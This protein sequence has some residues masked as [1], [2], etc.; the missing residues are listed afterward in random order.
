MAQENYSTFDF[1]PYESNFATGRREELA[2]RTR[3]EFN[4]N[5]AEYDTLKRTIGALETTDVDSK[6]INTLENDIENTMQGVLETG[7]YDLAN[8]AVSDSLTR[9]MTDNNVKNA[10]ESF[11]TMKKEKQL[12]AANPSK[13]KDYNIVPD[14]IDPETG[15]PTD[16]P[17]RGIAQYDSEGN[18]IMKDLRNSWDS[19]VQGAYLGNSEQVLDHQA[20]AYEIMKN[21]AKDPRAIQLLEKV[22]PGLPKDKA[23]KFLMSGQWLSDE[24]VFGLAE[25]L[26]GLYEGTDEGLQRQKDLSRT[27]NRATSQLFTPEQIRTALIEDLRLAGQTQIGMTQ[28][29]TSI[30]RDPVVKTTDPSTDKTLVYTPYSPGVDL[31]ETK[32]RWDKA[33][34]NIS[35]GKSKAFN[36]DGSLRSNT[37]MPN[38]VYEELSYKDKQLLGNTISA[39]LD[40]DRA[41]ALARAMEQL[42]QV[43]VLDPVTGQPS[44]STN[45]LDIDDDYGRY[46]YMLEKYQDI[47][48]PNA[49]DAEHIEALEKMFTQ[50]THQVRK[51][52]GIPTAGR[53]AIASL[54]TEDIISADTKL[55]DPEV[56][57]GAPVNIDQWSDTLADYFFFKTESDAVENK[58]DLI[59]AIENAAEGAKDFT[60]T[61][62]KIQIRGTSFDPKHPGAYEMIVTRN[63]K[64]GSRSIFVESAINNRQFF[65]PASRL[66]AI[67]QGNYRGVEVPIPTVSADGN[68]RYLKEDILPQR[69]KNGKLSYVSDISLI[70]RAPDGTLISS[71]PGAGNYINAITEGAMKTFLNSRIPGSQVW[72]DQI[73][74]K[75]AY[76]NP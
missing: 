38:P 13:Y 26:V 48:D 35:Q 74:S 19:G 61:P 33:R 16:D 11:Q 4:Q 45:P 42:A 3:Q 66:V 14:L 57:G 65:E 63:D 15:Q 34:K 8:F 72:H 25:Q 46:V 10:V 22:Y 41:T 29:L 21:I 60:D 55:Y 69:D 17:V 18:I 9:F 75:D 44:T 71:T 30:P 50:G 67:Q 76:Q 58:I 27:I 20:K 1:T 68:I 39:T 23:E 31:N 53:E 5:K 32:T 62:Y 24:K 6:Y 43:Q 40:V 70:V 36:K 56:R 73:D 54:M 47:R 37:S 28:T 64:P 59:K 51:I 52:R 49:T 2:D 12:I 7:R